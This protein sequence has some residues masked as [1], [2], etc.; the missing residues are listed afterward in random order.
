MTD[1]S[2]EVIEAVHLQYEDDPAFEADCMVFLA[3]CGA[4][5]ELRQYAE[6]RLKEMG[7]CIHCGEMLQTYHFREYHEETMDY[8][9]MYELYCPDCDIAD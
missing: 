8:E 4:D 1:R 9:D 2:A 5:Y 3:N 7:R 6:D